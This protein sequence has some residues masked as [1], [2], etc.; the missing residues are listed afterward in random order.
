[1]ADELEACVEELSNARDRQMFIY[2]NQL[3]VI[4]QEPRFHNR[5][6]RELKQA[7]AAAD[8]IVSHIQQILKQ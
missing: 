4:S 5:L 1:M 7:T 2:L 3:P 8:K 6:R